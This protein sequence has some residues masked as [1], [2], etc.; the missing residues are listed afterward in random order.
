MGKDAPAEGLMAMPIVPLKTPVA[1]PTT[2]SFF[3]PMTGWV[4]KPEMP[5]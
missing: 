2:P 1:K 3:A 4:K 5:S